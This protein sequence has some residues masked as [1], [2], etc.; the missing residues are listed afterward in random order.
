[1]SRAAPRSDSRQG[2]QGADRARCWRRSTPSWKRHGTDKTR[3]LQ[4]QIW[5]KDIRDREAMN[6]VWS[7]WLPPDGAPARACV[8]ADMADPRHLVEIMVTTCK[9]RPV[10]AGPRLLRPRNTQATNWPRYD[11]GHVIRNFVLIRR[12]VHT[13]DPTICATRALG[14]TLPD[15]HAA[16]IALLPA[17]TK[18]DADKEQSTCGQDRAHSS[19][20]LSARCWRLRRLP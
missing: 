19:P 1:M 20:S 12:L 14:S 8:Q 6:E 11:N 18:R 5:V 13:P 9:W 3:L 10:A 17:D 7:A 15:C 4:A 2:H 16:G